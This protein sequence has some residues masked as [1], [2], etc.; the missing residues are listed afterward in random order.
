MSS[1]PT[2]TGDAVA[3]RA[4]TQLANFTNW[5]AANNVKGIVGEFGWPQSSNPGADP[6]GSGAKFDPRWDAVAQQW[7]LDANAAGLKHLGCQMNL[8][9]NGIFWRIQ[10]AKPLV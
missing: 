3:A 6:L 4:R 2:G 1:F 7:Y 8:D 9:Q 5:L 10:S